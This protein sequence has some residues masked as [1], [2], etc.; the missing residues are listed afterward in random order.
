M[1]YRTFQTDSGT[2]SLGI[3][4]SIHIHLRPKLRMSG[5]TP[6]LSHIPT[7]CAERQIC[8]ST[9]YFLTQVSFRKFK[10]FSAVLFRGLYRTSLAIKTNLFMGTHNKER[11]VRYSITFL[12][13]PK[14]FQ[15]SNWGGGLLFAPKCINF[16]ESLSLSMGV[17]FFRICQ[18]YLLP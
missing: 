18:M 16:T 17:L 10:C 13:I 12:W 9:H 4:L 6:P 8:F 3:N 14:V 15:M 5:G 2:L 7:R 11:E 1:D